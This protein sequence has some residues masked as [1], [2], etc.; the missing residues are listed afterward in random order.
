MPS[1]ARHGRWGN[2]VF[3]YLFMR[4]LAAN[5][6]GSI[7]LNRVED[8]INQMLCVYEDMADI[9]T[10][11]TQPDVMLLDDYHLFPNA[12]NYIA[13]YKWRAMFVTARKQKCFIVEKT[14]DAINKPLSINAP[15]VEVEGLFMN[16]SVVY[17]PHKNFILSKL[18]Q[19]N[20]DFK[21][22][23]EKCV[24]KFAQGKTTVGIHI[25][26]GDFIQNPLGQLFQI[27]IPARYITEWLASNIT[28]LTNPII[29]V[30]SDDPHAYKDIESAGFNVIST[31]HL[32]PYGELPFKYEQLEWEILRH[33]DVLLTS[34]SSFSFSASLLNVKSAAC[35]RF[36]LEERK[37]M[38][39][40]PWNA[41]PLQF[42]SFAGNFWSYL[43]TRFNL[44]LKMVNIRSACKRLLKDLRSWPFWISI[45]VRSL[46][47]L[48]GFSSTFVV[49]L[50]KLLVLFK[51]PNAHKSHDRAGA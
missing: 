33:C 39:F 38:Q 37:Y 23:I 4:V 34:N 16:N 6:N 8:L 49:Q 51:L 9:P 22:I 27:P 44:V 2:M 36:S 14:D 13:P 28:S 40:D 32:L 41:E 30:C 24:E 1:F 25:R 47:Y 20:I 15:S 7:E 46:Y 29:Y 17:L 50:L 11:R 21:N 45:N 43:Y 42:C 26:R 19:P 48:H 3:Q 35:Y 10:I 5:N 12:L 31:T 18:F